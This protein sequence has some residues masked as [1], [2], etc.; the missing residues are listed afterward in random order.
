M[1][2]MM[3]ME[4]N[5]LF[6]MS[7]GGISFFHVLFF[8]C[9]LLTFATSG[10]AADIDFISGE[11]ELETTSSNATQLSLVNYVAGMDFYDVKTPQGE[12]SELI[13]PGYGSN[14]EIGSPKLPVL[15]KLIEL[16]LDAEVHIEIVDRD[17]RLE[18]QEYDLSDL[19]IT[20][21]LIPV[22]PSQSKSGDR[23]KFVYHPEA[24]QQ[25]KYAPAELVTVEILGTMR[26]VRLARLN[27]AP[28][29]YNP[30][31]N[32]IKVYT[33]IEVDVHFIGG[34][35]QRTEQ[36]KAAVYS[37]FFQPL[38]HQIINSRP[39]QIRDTLTRYPVKYVIV[40]DPMFESILQPFIEWKQKK[41]FYVVEAYT[42]DPAVGSTTSSIHS[43]LQGLYDSGT[44]GD[45]SPSFVLFV[46]DTGQVPAYSG[47]EGGHVT[48]LHYCEFTG[49]DF[50]EMYYG[51]FSATSL[52]E[53]QPQID[54]TLEY[55][56]YLM[57]DPSFLDEVV[58]ISGVDGTYA[59]THGNGQI[60]Y[61][62]TY[63]FNA[64]HGLTSH[65][66][67]YPESG[68]SDAQIR[69]HVSDGAAYANYTA[70]GSSSGWADPS[71]S[72]SDVASLQNQGKYPLM[73]G[74]ACLTNKFEVAVCFGEALLRAENKGALGY[75]G[76]SNSTYWDE[77]YYWGVGFGTV[78]PNPT[79]ESTGLGTYD[80]AFH[81]HEEDED[82]WYVTQAGMMFAGNLAVT[83]GGSRVSYYWEIYHLMGDPSLMV[84]FGQPDAMSA[85]YNGMLPLG[86]G[87][88]TVTTEP[89]AYVALS[90]NGDL[91]G[92]ALANASGQADLTFDPIDT[93]GAADI[94]I[95]KQNRQ[96]HIGE[97]VVS[98]ADDPY[99]VYDSHTINDATGN[100]N[101]QAD[102][103]EGIS[104]D[105]TIEN[106]GNATANNVTASLSAS[107]FYITLTDNSA[108]FNT[109]PA[110]QTAT[111][112]DAFGFDIADNIPDQ[113]S[114]SFNLEMNSVGRDTW[115]S[116]F[117]IIANAPNFDVGQWTINDDSGDSNGRLDPGETIQLIVPTSNNGHATSSA[118]TGMLFCTSPYITITDNS[119]SFGTM[120]PGASQNAQFSLDVDADAPIGESV[121]LAYQVSAGNYDALSDLNASIGIILEDFE[122]GDFSRFDWIHGGNADW[123]I[124]EQDVYEGIYS[125]ESGVVAHNESSE[126]SI[127]M[128]SGSG[129]ISFYRK[130]SSESGYDYLKFYIDGVMQN[131]WGGEV[132]WGQVSYD[133]A[134]GTH[135]FMW[136]YEK[137]GSVNNGSDKAWIDYI[138]FPSGGG[139]GSSDPN[140]QLSETSLD[141]GLT[142]VGSSVNRTLT[143]SNN[144]EAA[145]QVTNIASSHN[146]YSVNETNFSINPDDSRNVTVTFTPSSSGQ[147]N[148]SLTISSNDP[149]QG[150]VTVALQGSGSTENLD[151]DV[152]P[153]SFDEELLTGATA[154]RQLTVS[155]NS[156]SGFS[157]DIEIEEA[158]GSVRIQ[159]VQYE[160][161]ELAKGEADSRHGKP[162]LRDAGG[163]DQFGYHWIDSDEAGGPGFNWIDISQ[164]GTS[165]SLDDDDYDV[166]DLGFDFPFY[167][168]TENSISISSNGYLTFGVP[169]EDSYSNQGIPNTSDPNELIAIFWDDLDPSSGGNIYYYADAAQ[170]RWIVQYDDVPRYGSNSDRYTF[171]AI[172]H[173]NG[174]ILFQYQTMEG[175]LVSATIGVENSSGSD[176]LETVSNA[177]YMH[178]A[179]AVRITSSPTWIQVDPMSG[180]VG[181]NSELS[182]NVLFNAAGLIGGDYNATILIKESGAT[183]A[184]V[185]AHLHV[186][187]APDIQLS[188]TNFDFGTHF[189][190]ATVQR[191]LTVSNLGTDQLAVTGMVSSHTDFTVDQT[192]FSLNPGQ[193]RD[194]TVTFHPSSQGATTGILTIESSDPDEQTVTVGLQGQGSLPPDIAVQP[195][196]MWENLLTGET[197]TQY[198][199]IQN[200]GY[201]DLI[202][203]MWL[204]RPQTTRTRTRSELRSQKNPK[205]AQGKSIKQGQIPQGAEYVEGQVIVKLKPGVNPDQIKRDMKA[206]TLKSLN[207][208]GAEVWNLSDMS[209]QEAIQRYS[210]DPYF[211]YIEPNYRL[212]ALE[213]IPNDPHFFQLWGMH[214]TGQTGGQD[215]AD[216]DA[217][218]AWDIGVGGDVIVGVIDTGV[219]YNHN[220]LADNMWTNPGEIPD[221]NIDDDNNGYVDDIHGWDFFYGD[222]NPLDGNRH[223]THCSG[224][225]AGVG[226]DGVGVAGVCWQAKIMALKF[227]D[228]G[229]SGDTD[230]AISA[231]EYAVMMG[232]NLTSNSWG[233]GGFSQ[234]MH[235]AISAAQ[236]AGQLFIAAAGNDYESDN[237]QN[238]H[239]PSNYDLDSVISVAATTHSDEL[240]S[241]SNVGQESV[242][243]GA[244]GTDI[245][246]TTPGNSYEH[247]SGTSMATPHV[248]GAAALLWSS[249]P[250]LS[251]LEIKEQLLDNVDLTPAMQGRVLSN[252]RL[253]I[254]NAM[255]GLVTWVVTDPEQGVV[256]ANSTV[257]IA[258]IFDASGLDGGVYDANIVISSNDPDES[259]LIVPTHLTVTGAPDIGISDTQL[260]FGSQFLNTES[261]LNLTISNNGTDLLTISSISTNHNDFSVDLN[262]FDY[263]INPGDSHAIPVIFSPS[264]VGSMNGTLSIS[265]NDSDQSTL[266]VALTGQGVTPPN[267]SV[268]PTSV[269]HTLPADQ[270]G[271]QILTIQNTGVADLNFNI[272]LEEVA[273]ALAR[274]D[275]EV[276]THASQF[277]SQ[278]KS[279]RLSHLELGKGEM[280]PRHGD[281]NLRGSGG[282]DNFGYRWIDSD[283]PGGPAFNWFDI[284]GVGTEIFLP[285]DGSESVDLLFGFP[286]YGEIK[287]SVRISSNGYLTFTNNG[288]GYS[289]D[290][291]PDTS[292][293]N[294]MIAP[295]WDDLNPSLTGSIYY[296]HDVSGNRFI[297]Q[298]SNVLH[299]G[300]TEGNY[301]FQ[302][303]LSSGGSILFQYL[304]MD[305][306]TTGASVGIE[307]SDGSDGL[308]VAFN[309]EYI[310]DELAVKIRSGP[311]WLSVDTESGVISG[312]SSLDILVLFD[313]TGLA[314]G[315]YD[316]NILI[317]SNDP[318]EPQLTVPAHLQVGGG[319][320]PPESPSQ[321]DAVTQSASS[322]DLT[323][324]DNSS[325]EDGFKIERRIGETGAFVEIGTIARNVTAYED[326][327][328][329]SATNYCY[330]IRAYNS[331]GQSGYSNRACDITTGTAPTA[332]SNLSAT[333][334]GNQ[335]DLAWDD[336][337]S[338][339]TTY[340]VE[341]RIG[342][343]GNFVQLVEL[344][345]NTTAYADLDIDIE[346]EYCYQV[347]AL[348]GTGNSDYSNIDCATTLGIVPISPDNLTATAINSGQIDLA[349]DDNSD[350]ETHFR[351]E[352]RDGMNGTFTQ[353]GELGTDA[354]EFSDTTVGPDQLYCYRIYALNGAGNSDYSNMDCA[355]TLGIVPISPDN[356][357]AA[358]I[359]S[360]QIDLAWDDNSDN[361]TH[362]RVERRDGMNSTFTQIGELDADA[363]EFSDTTVNPDQLYCYRVYAL[364]GAGNS[365][366]SNMDCATTPDI[367][368]IAPDNLTATAINSGQIDLAWDDNS[369]NETHFRVERRDGMNGTFIQI[370]E[371][372]ADETE[373]SDT[374]VGLD[375]LYCYRVYALNG[376]GNSDY[377]NIDCATT[378]VT[379][380][381]APTTLTATAINS[382][383]IDLTWTDNASNEN[384]FAV[385][386]RATPTGEFDLIGTVGADVVTYQ[387]QGLD[388]E[389]L[390]CYQVR[391]Y[392]SG[393]NSDY[394]NTDC[395]TTPSENEPPTAQSQDLFV[396]EDTALEILLFGDDPESDDITYHILTNPQHGELIGVLPMLIYTPDHDYFGQ[397]NFTFQVSDGELDSEPAT[398]SI[399]VGSVNDA[400]TIF[401]I[402]PDGIDDVADDSFVIQWDDDDPDHDAQIALYYD[403]NNTGY[404]GQLIVSGLSEDDLSDEWIW[405]T[406][407]ITEGLYYL[408]AI[409]QDSENA[410]DRVY[411]I[412][413]VMVVHRKKGDL[414]GDGFVTDADAVLISKYVLENLEPSLIDAYVADINDDNAIDILDMILLVNL[415]LAR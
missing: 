332:P 156:G 175:N 402:E 342:E 371:L 127:S 166:A 297:V 168:E 117:S 51:R 173:A 14:L 32:S 328:L 24:Y 253:N 292:D 397:D 146:D 181:A 46:G 282:P 382:G 107:D 262:G 414:D 330:Q 308:L 90:M 183:V 266:T 116:H 399:Q 400:P 155:N 230:G 386:R 406:S 378:P 389:T 398:V 113:H 60:N 105:M 64:A 403:T 67:L 387:D 221:N 294:D 355:T 94:V 233:G 269:S 163:P 195:T 198:L 365:G 35:L 217:P 191:T 27:I 65:T 25:N 367:V 412:G 92:A 311:E 347:Y 114:I 197:A 240:A 390:Y 293:P 40:S 84:Y 148:G 272:S 118:A 150:N 96:P 313:A 291:I 184:S 204:E 31:A 368:P 119:H 144:G 373:F 59:P 372:D 2:S 354:T 29:Q 343:I 190:G 249:A 99:L 243:L 28:I 304:E 345:P 326:N 154:D 170:N 151:I 179:L 290:P 9:F 63:Y 50:P 360:G 21:P 348:N 141:F 329:V 103:G 73:V 26:G 381:V 273:A 120:S 309:T 377:S 256:P 344:A 7:R 207:L 285:D 331:A 101:G 209:V 180:T 289:N 11:T 161:V 176:G 192:I 379:A 392:N 93:P 296:Y 110:N 271:S 77:D 336:N 250:Q 385:E 301:T 201:S 186:T 415:I 318:D 124:I 380:P 409:I 346:V 112:S 222:N 68:S 280:D 244:P 188:E 410:E 258:V 215:D 208:I 248:A 315:G 333:A 401:I 91:Y 353:I 210:S 362:F 34:D 19:G 171:Q 231:L 12:F 275:A 327:D 211:E 369:D 123:G 206:T 276:V 3:F 165:L 189:V 45:P 134:E 74:N 100:N 30:D 361:E 279:S 126:L 218:N 8:S 351:V 10:S 388:E 142:L 160:Y 36:L 48:D 53:L 305:G 194:V 261:S 357:T 13:L 395:A 224:T 157:F 323:W 237:D 263:T 393:G 128:T 267:I 58:M 23:A 136:A 199:T 324:V 70:H 299:Y 167:G 338:N 310:H 226:N 152:S 72:V 227:L 320:Y 213:T 358:A 252:G 404:D 97:V 133:V 187:G 185:P 370:D 284:A 83:E 325:N 98:P 391:T 356:L 394:S 78:T 66:Y 49:D 337:A 259:P 121:T 265:S 359:N 139:G 143:I 303:I 147:I 232:A 411:S 85:S 376:A 20:R 281:P 247:L 82:D 238:P 153:T 164:T 102:F 298:Y 56:Q 106:L 62:T 319:V 193:S 5:A 1:R 363:T 87:S 234:A 38:R 349:W 334:N 41:G 115:T 257:T 235:D 81:D 300:S 270:T 384:G 239:Y 162:T 200:T 174:L 44:P 205:S 18:V 202:F 95:T 255:R 350:N 169:A 274:Q 52:S 108:N 364:N 277:G 339:E 76:G 396:N 111:V 138:V 131:E 130:V 15:H 33:R 322:I 177:A 383:R 288:S 408:Y 374:T 286:F 220:D 132:S 4:K 278:I 69:Q 178:D 251:N 42:D 158:G 242:D 135:T 159:P 172:L 366:Y 122:T 407:E 317:D 316:A 236:D 335:I 405:D 228:D 245:Y 302:A 268:F 254:A 89:G 57:D 17:N 109:I 312:N 182:L 413:K 214:N 22:Q 340:R 307:N 137:D 145:L 86:S 149:D 55:E 125:A 314:L 43:Y 54:K 225:I 16:P 47:N 295:F 140:I 6:T 375:Q 219:D 79:Y 37:P 321:L 80:S 223:G 212:Y 352:R 264:S 71:F 216:I 104:L 129:T 241:F 246:S 287:N 39:T 203:N 196:E 61:G 260:D 306:E 229:G 88:F 75:I 283:E 341:R